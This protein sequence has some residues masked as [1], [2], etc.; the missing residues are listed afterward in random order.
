MTFIFLLS[1][2]PCQ[3]S[4]ADFS[5]VLWYFFV[6]ILIAAAFFL[7]S[8]MLWVLFCVS[9]QLQLREHM[10]DKYASYSAKA[11]H[12]KF[13]EENVKLWPESFPWSKELF[14][15]SFDRLDQ[16]KK[17]VYSLISFAGIRRW[18][19]RKQFVVIFFM[20]KCEPGYHFL[21]RETA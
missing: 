17:H 2:L 12:L 18:T 19:C 10:G 20:L 15:S 4:H 14:S 6:N 8:V 11:R 5:W 1:H 13:L 9:E 7:V 3:A 21:R 16:L